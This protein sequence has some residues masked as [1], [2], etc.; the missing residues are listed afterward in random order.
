MSK[1]LKIMPEITEHVIIEARPKVKEN[2][3]KFLDPLLDT[4]FLN[5]YFNKNK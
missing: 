3:K 4:K 5:N 1:E 2:S